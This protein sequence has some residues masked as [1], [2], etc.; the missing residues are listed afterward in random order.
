MKAIDHIKR[1]KNRIYLCWFLLF[2]QPFLYFLPA[3]YG[4]IIWFI[5]TLLAMVIIRLSRCNY[6]KEKV[7]T[8]SSN[9]NDYLKNE[10]I[11]GVCSSCH[12]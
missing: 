4:I 1:N 10:I 12:K 8:N 3:P 6:C 11:K 2:N 5:L 9:G 7:M